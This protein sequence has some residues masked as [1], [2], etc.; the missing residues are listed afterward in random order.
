M[1]EVATRGFTRS[2]GT[3]L[4]PAA[5]L[6]VLVGTLQLS[7]SNSARADHVLCGAGLQTIIGVNQNDGFHRGVAAWGPGMKVSDTD[8]HCERVSVVALFRN[9]QQY[10]E[11]GWYE[12]REGLQTEPCGPWPDHPRLFATQKEF[13]PLLCEYDRINPIQPPPPYHDFA[14]TI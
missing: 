12:T 8:I 4:L 9:D 1:A 2:L 11:V 6:G 10:V 3:W 5:A 7:V 14:S 13:G